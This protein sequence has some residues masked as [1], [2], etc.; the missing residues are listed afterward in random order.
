MKNQLQSA[1]SVNVLGVASNSFGGA[2]PMPLR[3][4]RGLSNMNQK[5]NSNNNHDV[6]DNNNKA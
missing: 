6:L 5:Q 3:E 1:A 2:G 4:K